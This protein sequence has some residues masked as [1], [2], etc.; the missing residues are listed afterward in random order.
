MANINQQRRQLPVP[1]SSTSWVVCGTFTEAS[2]M[3]ITPVVHQ[4]DCKTGPWGSRH[5]ATM[6]NPAPCFVGRILPAVACNHIPS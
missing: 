1:S 2:N 6:L 5:S 4:I 3:R